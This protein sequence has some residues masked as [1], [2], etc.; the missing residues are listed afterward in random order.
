MLHNNAFYQ[1]GLA[2]SW[3]YV[4]LLIVKDIDTHSETGERKD[5]EVYSCHVSPDGSRLVTAAGGERIK[6]R[7]I[8]TTIDPEQ[9]AMFEFGRRKL[10]TMLPMRISPSRSS[11]LL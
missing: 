11:L 3:R 1:A 9:M 4:A 6:L 8:L 5:F 7:T 2:N 10:Y